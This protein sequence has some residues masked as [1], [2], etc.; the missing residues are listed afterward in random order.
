MSLGQLPTLSL[1]HHSPSSPLFEHY[2]FTSSL[3]EITFVGM[4]DSEMFVVRNCTMDHVHF[5]VDL[6]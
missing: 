6:L 1:V 3:L 4:L 2:S 5:L